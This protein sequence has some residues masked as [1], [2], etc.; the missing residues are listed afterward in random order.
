MK[1]QMIGFILSGV[2]ALSVFAGCSPNTGNNATKNNAAETVSPASEET[3]TDQ[4]SSAADNG[5]IEEP[6]LGV[7][8]AMPAEWLDQQKLSISNY[9]NGFTF[10]F[11]TEKGLEIQKELEENMEAN[12][13]SEEGYTAEQDKLIAQRDENIIQF[14]GILAESDGVKDTQMRDAFDTAKELGE[15]DG[16]VYTLL[17]NEKIDLSKLSETDKAEYEKFASGN[18]TFEE[19]LELLGKQKLDTDS[20]I[21]FDSKKLDGSAIDSSVF[22][23]NKLTAINIWTTW[24]GP[25]VKELP[26]LQKLYENL[27][28]GT[29]F[30][31]I[32]VDGEEEPELA[33]Q[34]ADKTGIKYDTVAANEAMKNGFLSAI[35]SYPT[36]IF[37]DSEGNL[38]GEPM[39]G[40]PSSD[41]AG[42][43]RQAMEERL[44]LLGQ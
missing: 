42:A 28:E 4:G 9:A 25:C 17:T 21:S 24:C 27:P 7:R 10:G 5:K 38:V 36:T 13:P 20:A 2:I 37:V 34:I 12:P 16:T 11:I 1:K 32:C 40:A 8:F 3:S 14:C 23:N 41:V 22:A 31:S 19:S 26:E 43:Y 29:N 6:T 44:A 39:M 18:Q 35:Q 30:M 15:K 33:Q